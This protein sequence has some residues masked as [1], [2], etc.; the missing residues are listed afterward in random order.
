MA[1]DRAAR[2]EALA[3]AATRRS[4]GPKRRV[5]RGK[6]RHA[7]GAGAQPS[8]GDP[9]HA[10]R[11]VQIPTCVAA[12]GPR[13]GGSGTADAIA[14]AVGSRLYLIR[15]NQVDDEARVELV[16]AA[17][18]AGA[19]SEP[20]TAHAAPIRALARSPCGRFLVSGGDDKRVAV[21]DLT[22]ALAHSDDPKKE[23]LVWCATLAKK[24]S[25][26]AFASDSRHVF[27][28]DKFGD[29]SC[30][31]T[32]PGVAG[33]EAPPAVTM[34]LCLGHFSTI[35]TCVA[36]SPDGAYL[37]TGD[38]DGKIR[39]SRLPAWKDGQ[40]AEGPSAMRAPTI[41]SYC[42]G[43]EGYVAALCWLPAHKG[44]EGGCLASCGGDGTVRLWRAADGRPIA[45]G[46]P[47][48]LSP[49]EGGGG[50]G[51]GEGGKASPLLGLCVVA[52]PSGDAI[53]AL[54]ERALHIS[55]LPKG[56]LGS[57]VRVPFG[58]GEGSAFLPVGVS[59]DADGE[60]WV[61]G[62]EARG[63]GGGEG[64]AIGRLWIA[65]ASGGA[66]GGAG[67][68]AWHALRASLSGGVLVDDCDGVALHQIAPE[69]TRQV[70]S[71]E[72]RDARK[73]MRNDVKRTR[74]SK[75]TPQ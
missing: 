14:Y 2:T 36:C 64:A 68:G 26:V 73:R 75:P 7:R 35:V 43:H 72:E 27:A 54:S 19:G 24:V 17:S 69:L 59:A 3:A 8:K 56:G 62:A 58:G 74:I 28:G 34:R 18:T 71:R 6:G 45:V 57:F 11:D 12:S 21:W 47:L 55:P 53:A 41:Q 23:A 31:P 10:S 46:R 9:G 44:H 63:E 60:V 25:A 32:I 4:G 37:A 42:L 65:S 67:V 66:S 48:D 70:F 29:V 16:T 50:G 52:G 49:S 5:R 33:A 40:E 13:I 38:R 30:A 22:R 1:D 51:G 61:A 15:R 39:V 20:A